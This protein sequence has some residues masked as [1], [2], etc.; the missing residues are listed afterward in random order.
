MVKFI[1]NGNRGKVELNLPTS[2]S[3]ITPEYLTNVTKHIKIGDNYSLIGILYRESLSSLILASSRKQKS[4]TTGVIPI[5]I[6]SG[7]TEAA[8]IKNITLGEKLIISPSDIA[9][10]H[11]VTCP[12]N[13][14]TIDHVLSCVEGDKDIY[15]L[16]C[17]ENTPCYYL[18]FKLVPNCN[19]HG[20]YSAEEIT[21]EDTTYIKFL[22][23]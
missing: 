22:K 16:S 17:K 7:N 13:K 3:D 19:I 18:E 1:V 14:L 2:I 20:S 9:L 11:H 6:K 8:Y 23:D 10:G 12:K 15:S 5:F 21:P 4:I